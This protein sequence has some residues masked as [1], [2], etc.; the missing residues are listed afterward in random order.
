M[1]HTIHKS[2][3]QPVNTPPKRK[4][5]SKFP[6]NKMLKLSD[7]ATQAIANSDLTNNNEDNATTEDV[8][9]NNDKWSFSSFVPA[10]Q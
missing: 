5:S 1:A 7:I 2:H 6:A 9:M 10:F 8:I 3:E 4:A